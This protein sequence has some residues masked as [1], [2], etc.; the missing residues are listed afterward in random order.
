[1]QRGKR[2]SPPGR[3]RPT[4]VRP[5]DAVRGGG[6]RRGDKRDNCGGG[7][8]GGV[9][10]HVLVA[11]RQKAKGPADIALKKPRPIGEKNGPPSKA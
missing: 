3:G 7:A 5:E 2:V 6:D 4:N 9:V 11:I 1:V 10:T 8:C